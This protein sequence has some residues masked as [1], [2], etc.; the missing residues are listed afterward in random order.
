M[1]DLELRQPGI[2]GLVAAH[3]D[4]WNAV[5]Q[6][7]ERLYDAHSAGRVSPRDLGYDDEVDVL[8]QEYNK[9]LG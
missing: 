7:L 4:Q 3:S 9:W 2:K 8:M 5:V 6:A 1:D